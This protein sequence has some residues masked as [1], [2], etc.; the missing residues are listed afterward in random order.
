MK[1]GMADATRLHGDQDFARTGLRARNIY[2]CQR[3]LEFLQDGSFH[4]VT[5]N[6]AEWEMVFMMRAI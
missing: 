3:L 5:V 4:A 1:I 6:R 2:D